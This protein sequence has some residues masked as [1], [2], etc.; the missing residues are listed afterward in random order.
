MRVYTVYVIYEQRG[1]QMQLYISNSS[2]KPIY[3][4]ICAQI[5][6]AILNNELKEGE[7]LPS[8]RY[9]AKELRI[10]VI[11]T[12]RAYEELEKS[13]FITTQAGRGSFVSLKNK[14]IV[15]EELYRQIEDMMQKAVAI[16]QTANISKDELIEIL[17][18][19]YEE[20]S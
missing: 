14:E 7:A 10:S 2:E 5:K 19:C 18:I 1:I 20:V 9:L 16:A 11:T 13:G 4:Q 6:T 12:K 8:I 3:E 15:R 17:E